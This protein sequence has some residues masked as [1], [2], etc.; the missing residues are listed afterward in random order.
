MQGRFRACKR[1]GG[2]QEIVLQG[3][4]LFVFWERKKAELGGG[5]VGDFTGLEM[6][7]EKKRKLPFEKSCMIWKGTNHTYSPLSSTKNFFS[8]PQIENVVVRDLVVVF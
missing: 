7:K 4:A 1:R 2:L 8:L 3:V 6:F 5:G